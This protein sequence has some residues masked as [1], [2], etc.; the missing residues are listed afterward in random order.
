MVFN[1]VIYFPP[2]YSIH[3]HGI[4]EIGIIFVTSLVRWTSISWFHWLCQRVVQYCKAPWLL[5][6][7][8]G[9]KLPQG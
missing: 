2:F 7:R 3:S 1:L 9:S 8:L 6:N 4:F 5:S